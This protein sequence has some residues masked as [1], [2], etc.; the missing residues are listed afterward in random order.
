MTSIQTTVTYLEDIVNEK[1]C[2]NPILTHRIETLKNNL[3]Q[4]K[5]L[6]S[7]RVRRWDALGKAWKWMAGS[8]DSD[9][10]KN[11]NSSIN[12]LVDNNNDQVEINEKLEKTLTNLTIYLNDISLLD[13]QNFNEISKELDSLKIMFHLDLINDEIE[14]IRNAIIFSK[15]NILNNKLLSPTETEEI[16]SRLETQGI[17]QNLIDE[18]LQF[19]T[20]SVVTNGE[21]IL[22][23]VGIPNFSN[24][25]FQQ[26]R[27]E[28]VIN[29]AERIMIPGKI[30]F[31]SVSNLYLLITP[32]TELANWTICK[33]SELKDVSTDGCISNVITGSPSNCSY[34]VIYNHIPVIEMGTTTVLL[35]DVHDT[36]QNTCGA[37]N[38]QLR[39]S[40]L[41]V[42]ENCSIT[43]QNFT[44]TNAVTRIVEQPFFAPSTDLNISRTQTYQ[45]VGINRIHQLHLKNI[46]KLEYLHTK[47]DVTS[48]SLW[49]GFSFTTTLIILLG[50]YIFVKARQQTAS[51]NIITPQEKP[52]ATPLH[53]IYQPPTLADTYSSTS[54]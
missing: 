2:S 50:F 34:E 33:T 53:Y 39:G 54:R 25:T 17:H 49:G 32:C 37:T 30:F 9:D 12:H 28:A 47:T 1:N 5:P 46:K 6:N 43:F 10:L 31:K 38:R 18:A 13:S 11:I 36:L 21:V 40:Y 20:T 41:I 22:Y 16:T 27:V 35:N 42:Y 23:I 24:T 48:W 52:Q 51:V 14:A 4:V 19:A 45:T 29:Q 7:K 15:L 44:F 26:L 3:A 8:P